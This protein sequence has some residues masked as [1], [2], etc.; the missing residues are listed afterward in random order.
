MLLPHLQT[1]KRCYS[2][3]GKFCQQSTEGTVKSS[4]T[5]IAARTGAE[6]EVDVSKVTDFTVDDAQARVKDAQRRRL[7][8]Y[9]KE[10]K[11]LPKPSL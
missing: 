7:Q 5:W 6:E 10:G 4:A 2:S 11:S 9:E 8:G 1:S 3:L